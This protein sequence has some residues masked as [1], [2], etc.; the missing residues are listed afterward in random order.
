MHSIVILAVPG[1][2]LLDVAGPLDAFAEVNRILRRQIYRSVVVS[3]DGE[4]IHASSGVS[5]RANGALADYSASGP[6]SFLIAGSP[7]MAERELSEHQ[8]QAVAALCRLSCRY[9]SVCTGALLLAQTGLLNHRQ[10]TTH[11]S[12][13]G[14]L[15]RRHPAIEVN[16]D[17]LYVADG[18][19]RTAAGVTSGMDLALRFIEEDVGRETARDV[20]ANLVMFFRRPGGQGHFT[21]KQQVSTTGRAALQDLQ[22]WVLT[23]LDTTGTAAEMANHIN[24]SVRHLNRV[25][26]QEMGVSTGE[27]LEQARI[28]RAR[29]LLSERLPIKS[30]AAMCGY[31]SSDVM[32]RAFVK[33]TGMSPAMYQ[34]IYAAGK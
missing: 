2:Q 14:E 19:V 9:G 29:E 24:L 31:S 5:L 28:A 26:Q 34:K 12:V 3:L 1:V 6:M 21:R 30:V 13:A 18:P 27:W 7:E 23:N 4:T 20:A 22:R 10:V 15:S 25:F 16:A 32:R 8:R 11:W 33:V 17:A